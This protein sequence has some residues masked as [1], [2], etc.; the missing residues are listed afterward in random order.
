MVGGPRVSGVGLSLGVGRTLG[1]LGLEF[2]GM[3]IVG[4]LHVREECTAFGGL[5]SSPG[6]RESLHLD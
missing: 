1:C 4:I 5:G 6:N 3:G 2:R